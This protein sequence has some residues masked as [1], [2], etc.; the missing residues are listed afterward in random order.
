[1]APDPAAVERLN[2]ALAPFHLVLAIRRGEVLLGDECEI[3][4]CT[5]EEACPG[6]CWWV[7]PGLCSACAEVAQLSNSNSLDFRGT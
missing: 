4:G 5:E 3:C 1:M 7:A 6:G 2:E